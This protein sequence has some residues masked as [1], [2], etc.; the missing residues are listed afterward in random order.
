MVDQTDNFEAYKRQMEFYERDLNPKLANT[1][2][3]QRFALSGANSFA[4]QGFKALLVMNGGAIVLIPTAQQMFEKSPTLT[5]AELIWAATFFAAGVI[6]VMV[7][8]LAAF[9]QQQFFANQMHHE[10][11]YHRYEALVTHFATEGAA[12]EREKAQKAWEDTY[13]LSHRLQITAA[14]L[15]VGSLICFGIGSFILIM[16]AAS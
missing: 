7:A 5:S 2:D 1:R 6:L 9:Y 10:G 4:L 15:A 14:C 11:E 16:G 3:N 8:T 13:N 12:A